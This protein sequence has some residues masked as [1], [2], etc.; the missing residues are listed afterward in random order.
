MDMRFRKWNAKSFYRVGSQVTASGE[1]SKYKLD[2]VGVQEVR[3][4]GVAPNQ[5][6]THFS[7]E[8]GIRIMNQIQ[9]LLCIRKS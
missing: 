2:L 3:W 7:T 4:E 9:V 1:L 6:N 5:Q 8:R